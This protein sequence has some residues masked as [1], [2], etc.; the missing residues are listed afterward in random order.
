MTSTS[1]TE[2]PLDP[3]PTEKFMAAQL[4]ADGED[5]LRIPDKSSI[6]DDDATAVHTQAILSEHINWMREDQHEK[7]SPPSSETDEP[8]YDCLDCGS[9]R[10]ILPHTMQC[11]FELGPDNEPHLIH[12]IFPGLEGECVLSVYAAPKGDDSWYKLLSTIA[13]NLRSQGIRVQIYA[14]LW[15]NELT[16]E[17][18]DYSIHIIGYQGDRWILRA[19]VFVPHSTHTENDIATNLLTWA[20]WARIIMSNT[21][22]YRGDEPLPAL[23]PLPLHLPQRVLDQLQAQVDAPD[24][25]PVSA[26][27]GLMATHPGGATGNNCTGGFIH[28]LDHIEATFPA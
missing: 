22:I 4:P 6:S 19:V 3:P 13:Q 2:P 9:L 23:S 14:G 18:G 11:Y 12:C 20:H 8:L 17:Y 24:H 7:L 27:P 21:Q 26:H 28:M 15:G 25:S 1:H 5:V 16:A 10:F